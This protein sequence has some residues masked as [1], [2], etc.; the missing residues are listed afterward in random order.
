MEKVA[1]FTL[2]PMDLRFKI[3]R[4]EQ[5]PFLEFLASVYRHES[6]ADIAMMNSGNFRM[7]C[8]IEAGAVTFGII[9]NIIMDG[10]I[11]KI[12][13]APILIQAL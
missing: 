1:L 9:E 6:E 8:K 13:P 2:K 12:I 10:V 7:D 11:V 4:K 5:S 3:I